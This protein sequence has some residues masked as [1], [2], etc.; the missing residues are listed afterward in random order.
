M[1]YVYAVLSL[2]CLLALPWIAEGEPTP[3]RIDLFIVVLL[4]CGAFGCLALDK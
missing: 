3:L 2:G 1:R 4:G